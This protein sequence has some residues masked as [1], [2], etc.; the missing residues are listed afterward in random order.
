M[1]SAG[2]KRQARGGTP[3]RAETVART[4]LALVNTGGLESLTMRK[5]VG[6]LGVQP[7]ALYRLFGGK[8]DLLDEMA[9]T[10]LAGVPDRVR[11]DQDADWAERVEAL[12]HAVRECLLAQR[13][14]ARIVGGSYAAKG[15]ARTFTL[16]ATMVETMM[17]A[18]FPAESALWPCT[19]IFSFILGETL[20]QQGAA[21]A[22]GES[23]VAA[24]ISEHPSLPAVTA[25][26]FLDFDARFE[27]GLRVL[28]DGLRAALAAGE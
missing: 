9:E 22:G 10:V 1:S 14:G 8:R 28:L 16:A 20:E 17:D 25:D 24:R 11:L 12:A 13:D 18:G 2:E 6:V 15:H 26:R 23:A 5:L 3:L 7:P 4:A 19:T 21:D 27:F